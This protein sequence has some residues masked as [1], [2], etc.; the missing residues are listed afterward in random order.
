MEIK[1]HV[2]P[3]TYVGVFVILAVVTGTEVAISQAGLA[4]S[5]L[6]VVL[7][8]LATIKALLVAM[9]YMHL[10]YDAKW[11]SLSMVFPLLMAILLIVIVIIHFTY[12]Q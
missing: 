10:K 4:E 12:F 5:A 1:A 6:V 7:L 3:L 9:F 8:S 11:Y 2:K